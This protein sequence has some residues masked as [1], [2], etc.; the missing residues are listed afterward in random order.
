MVLAMTACKGGSEDDFRPE[1]CYLTIYVYAPSSPLL[2]RSDVNYQDATTQ[3]NDIKKLQLWVYK[4]ATGEL[5]SYLE[6][7]NVEVGTSSASVFTMIISPAFANAPENVDVYAL[8]NV[9]AG[10]TGYTFN[11]Q[12]TRSEL[13]EAVLKDDFFGV[14]DGKL[15]QAVPEDGLPM[16]AILK[17]QPVAGTFPAL[18]IGTEE[19]MATMLLTRAV[20]KVRFVLC[21]AHDTEDTAKQLHAITGINIDTKM[22][23]SQTFLMLEQPFDKSFNPANPLSA[24]RCHI[25]NAGYENTE[26]VIGAIDN[27]HISTI[28]IQETPSD[29]WAYDSSVHGTWADYVEAINQGITDGHLLEMGTTYLRESDKKITGYIT[30]TV[31]KEPAVERIT[32]FEMDKAGDFT[33]NHSWTVLVMFEGGK[34]RILN[35]VNIAVR[36][37]NNKNTDPHEV[38]NW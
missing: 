31:E 7:E 15:I 12:T 4:H 3:E 24:A 17:N 2:T 5:V 6:K 19:T 38:Y 16:T 26:A 35:V 27:S 1:E 29:T 10:N 36:E 33:R 22:I 11:R 30:Y 32:P 37:W 20:S 21:R 25:E 9:S 14:N 34:L 18:R 23:P 8:A 13:E 28:P